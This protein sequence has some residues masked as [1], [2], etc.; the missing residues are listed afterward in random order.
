MREISV[1]RFDLAILELIQDDAALT[2][3][4]LAERVHLSASQV[5]RRRQRLEETGVLQRTVA[6]IDPELAGIGAIAFAHVTLERHGE[7][8]TGDFERAVAVLPEVLECYSVTGEADYV[9]KLVAPDLAQLSD[10]LLKRLI[11]LPGVTHVRSHIALERVKQTTALPLDH[12]QH[13]PEA[14]RRLRYAG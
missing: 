3:A 7:R 2:N 4:A 8:R 1:D 9:L 13:A 12:L 6:L 11:A 14:A 10:L 5:G